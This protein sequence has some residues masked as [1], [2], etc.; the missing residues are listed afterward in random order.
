VSPAE[1]KPHGIVSCIPGKG[2]IE[3]IL[4]K[5]FRLDF[6]RDQSP[7]LGPTLMAQSVQVP[8]SEGELEKILGGASDD[9][10]PCERSSVAPS[11]CLSYVLADPHLRA[12][13]WEN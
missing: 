10:N 11:L 3:K 6:R 1:S 5:Y 4:W 8:D 13:P 2:G 7:A 12:R 9:Y